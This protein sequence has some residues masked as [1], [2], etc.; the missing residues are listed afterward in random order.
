MIVKTNFTVHKI[1]I[2]ESVCDIPAHSYI[3]GVKRH[4]AYRAVIDVHS[5]EFVGKNAQNYGGPRTVNS[6][7]IATTSAQ[8]L[9]SIIPIDFFHFFHFFVFEDTNRQ[10]LRWFHGANAT[11]RQII[12][13]YV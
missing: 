5:L 10:L 1:K 2:S 12:R 9:F 8:Q 3:K 11:A 7:C 13:P 4:G 6:C